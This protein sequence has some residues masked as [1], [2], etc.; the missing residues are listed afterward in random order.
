MKNM[1][2]CAVAN[3]KVNSLKQMRNKGVRAILTCLIC[4][5]LIPL[6]A[7]TAAGQQGGGS[8]IGT[9]YDPAG[10]RV[11]NAK[12][13]IRNNEA[14]SLVFQT[15]TNGEG[16]FN[17]PGLPSG[18][19]NITVSASGFRQQRE[20]GVI[21]EVGTQKQV[22]ITVSVGT[23][24]ETVTVKADSTE[25]TTASGSIGTVI[26]HEEVSNLPINGR[27][28]LALA[29][30]TPGVITVGGPV[31]EGVGDRGQ[32][33]S[34]M[35]VSGAPNASQATLLD[36]QNNVQGTTTGEIAINPTV[37]A[38][39]EFKI[40]SGV[41]SAEYGYTLG[42]VITIA[43]QSGTENFHGTAYEFFRND[44]LDARNYY[45][46]KGVV[47]P[48]FRYDQYGATAG[49]KVPKVPAFLFGNLEHYY[50]DKSSPVYASVPT[51]AERGGDFSQLYATNGTLTPIYDPST[52]AT[53]PSGSGVTRSKF[54]GNVIPKSELD[55][56]AVAIQTYF[57][58]LPNN[59]SGLYN[60][61][62]QSDN[63][64]AE[65]PSILYMTQYFIRAD[66]A[67]KSN[68][69]LFARYA[70]YDF[71]TGLASILLIPG[72][73]S[74]KDHNQNRSMELA[75]T[76][77]FSPSLINEFRVGLIR[78]TF[79]YRAG[80]YGQDW[81]AKLGLPSSI[82]SDTVP[83]VSNG[84]P[85]FNTTVGTRSYTD[86]E[87]SDTV[88][89]IIGAHV[90]KMGTDLRYNMGGNNQNAQPSGTYSFAAGLTG[91]PQ[92]QTGTGSTYASFLL[93]QVS[94]ATITTLIPTLDRQM[95]SAFFI[96]D[97]YKVSRRIIL[98]LGLRYEY[99]QAA[100][101]QNNMYSTFNPNVVDSVNG[102]QGAMQYAGNPGL[103]RNF[104]NENYL[105]FGPR[106]GFAISLTQDGKTMLRG[107]Y[108]IYHPME[109]NTLYTGDT[110]GA[111]N[112]TNYVAVTGNYPAFIF[113]QG[114][115]S[116]PIQPLGRALGPAAFLGNAV[117]ET[118]AVDK[119]PMSQQWN[120]AI[121]RELPY[122][123]VMQVAYVGNHATHLPQ[124]NYPVNHLTEA[125][126]ALG[127][128]L[129]NQVPNPY[130]GI[131]PAGSSVSGKTIGEAQ[132]LMPFPYYTGVTLRY[133]H[134]GGS[135]ANFIEITARRTAQKGITV[136]FSFTGQKVLD[137]P[138]CSSET[139]CPNIAQD[140][141]N[142]HAEHSLNVYDVSRRGSVAAQYKL[143]FGSGERF[144][145]QRNWINQ[146]IGGWAV[147]SIAIAQTG[148]PL[149]ITGANN[150]RATRPNFVPGVSYKA[151]HPT[152]Y[153]WFNTQAF[154]NPST[155]YTLGDVPRTMPNLRGPRA[156]NF[157]F[158]TFKENKFADG[159]L[160]SQFR[161]EMFNIFNHPNFSS[162]NTSFSPGTNGLNANGSFGQ[163][164]STSTDNREIQLALKLIF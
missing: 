16:L 141:N 63:L 24:S 27:S 38:V 161:V 40:Q 7:L 158:S 82:P 163:V 125:D 3:H 147:N 96:Q 18:S 86:P 80:T 83:L 143:P 54:P 21:V 106:V 64:L 17:S 42:G 154:V 119:T 53:N 148:F 123:F 58:P 93:G 77:V 19:Y 28:A 104:V 103:G 33:L 34:E 102:L 113:S 8:I 108:G 136:L 87:I 68:D 107:G 36:G 155:P 101:E 9:V 116:P 95:A 55:P 22:D 89:K 29:V 111:N 50:Y 78:N 135:T 67:L 5:F 133:P 39:R 62:T 110:T 117:S 79:T 71:Q 138:V 132:S 159:R 120:L 164:S 90:I 112:Q 46:T 31:V 144:A 60:P 43:T 81:P 14:T 109:Y 57:Y 11:P 130:Y 153:E 23:A 15:V 84:L 70:N 99:Q 75:Y 115:P 124:N 13:E 20:T 30:L 126:Y 49:G 45:A 48:L 140:P 97:D 56:A 145:S 157:D 74:R 47:K 44:F 146:I 32:A 51:A 91:N 127:L 118:L 98:N 88:T 122:N 152:I 72:S 160:T 149:A 134:I 128:A 85:A 162:P 52:T 66:A 6:C 139:G 137:V 142:L 37:D 35:M 25:L 1:R 92:S 121:G 76:H 59:T 12:V 129:E 105:D 156:I 4:V 94:S 69:T 41:V 26:D 100:Y 65:S 73:T 61:I 10:G 151:Q 2:P 131:V 150:N 114:L